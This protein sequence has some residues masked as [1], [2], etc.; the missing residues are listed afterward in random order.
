M[1]QCHTLMGLEVF[2]FWSNVCNPITAVNI[3][4]NIKDKVINQAL[5]NIIVVYTQLVLNMLNLLTGVS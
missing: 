4:A 5:L 1:L 2:S 3:D